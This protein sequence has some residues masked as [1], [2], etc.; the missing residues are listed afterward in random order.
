MKRT[1]RNGL[2]F[3]SPALL[4]FLLFWIL[5]VILSI[6]YSFTKWSIGQKEKYI[7]LKNFLDL[8]QD[9]LFFKAVSA[10][11]K[12]TILA[13]VCTMLIALFV[14][15]LLNDD[16]LRGGRFFKAFIMIP[17]VTDWVATSLVWQLF[18]LPY[19]G[20]LPGIFYSLGLQNWM[21]LRWTAS[22]DLAPY[23]IVIFIVWKT[24]GLYT[25]IFLAGLK[26]VPKNY[27]EA[28]Y[29]DG[30]NS[31][32]AFYYITMPLLRP[33]TVF[34]LVSSFVSTIG[35]FEPVFMLTG[36]GPADAT[37]VLPIFLYE[38]FFQFSKSGYASAAGILFLLVC[39]GF[40][41]IAARLLQY[42]YF[43]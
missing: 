16:K 13:V 10:S 18:F 7:G 19:S 9:E 15:I 12:V 34:V 41:L 25:I 11:A 14:A 33:I 4:Y 32:Q 3:I 42:S 35:L 31:V 26:S 28:S 21:G 20:V 17:V 43:E 27:L 40:A 37:R 36:G 39:L 6:Y 5:P 23:A 2:L 38:N 8:F 29:V 30:A 1:A 24:T 22:A